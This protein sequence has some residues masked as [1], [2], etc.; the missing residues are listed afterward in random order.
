MA[1]GN[2][3]GAPISAE[4]FKSSFGALE[5]AILAEWPA[6]EREAL[7][8]TAGELDQ[9]IDLVALKTEHTRTLVRRQ[10]AE[11]AQ[12]CEGGEGPK[13]AAES[14]QSRAERLLE[15]W[16]KRTQDLAKELR[17]N[18]LANAEKKVRENVLTSILVALGLG[19]VLGF[20]FG[21]LR[22]RDSH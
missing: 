13:A 20:L 12:L 6:I 19:L 16:Q 3:A 5:A 7:A 10:I 8:A 22:R 4:T 2:G 15:A 18:V 17:E 9:V 21:G 14:K 1:T 11:L